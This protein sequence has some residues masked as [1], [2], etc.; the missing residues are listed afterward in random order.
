MNHRDMV[1]AG[2]KSMKETATSSSALV[3][4]LIITIMFAAAVTVPGGIKGETGIP[5]YVNTKAFR[6]FMVA[7]VISLCSSTTSVMVFLGILTSRFAEDDFL[8]S[9]PT[10]LIDNWL[11]NPISIYW[12][13]DDCLLFCHFHYAP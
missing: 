12:G 9:L 1:E 7:D 6:I 8:T 2:E 10:K 5:I 13:H 4:T 3:A 11:F